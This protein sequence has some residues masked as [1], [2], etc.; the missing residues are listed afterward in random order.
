[1]DLVYF[2]KLNEFVKIGKGNPV[3]RL[4][5]IQ[6]CSPYLVELM[7]ICICEERDLHKQFKRYQVRTGKGQE[8]FFLSQEI[9]QYIDEHGTTGEDLDQW[10]EDRPWAANSWMTNKSY[11][12]KI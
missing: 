9:L 11:E 3:A 2:I 5:T 8:W 6:G 12:A 7:A 1:M 10:I 4:H